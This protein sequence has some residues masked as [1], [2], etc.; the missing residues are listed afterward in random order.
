MEEYCINGCGRE[1]DEEDNVISFMKNG[2][3]ITGKVCAA[4]YFDCD[5]IEMK[6]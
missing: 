4:C 1:V 5:E 6:K 2:R 3:K